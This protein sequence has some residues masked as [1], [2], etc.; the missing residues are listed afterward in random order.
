MK[1]IRQNKKE[2]IQRRT[3]EDLHAANLAK[4]ESLQPST[5]SFP[6]RL[7]SSR[8][9]KPPLQKRHFHVSQFLSLIT[10]FSQL[11]SILFSTSLFLYPP[12][13]FS[14]YGISCLYHN[15]TVVVES[16]RKLL[17]EGTILSTGKKV[18]FCKMTFIKWMWQSNVIYHVKIILLW[19]SIIFRYYDLY[20]VC[21]CPLKLR[22]AAFLLKWRTNI[23]L[24]PN[25]GT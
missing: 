5:S 1:T 17:C 24:L 23:F 15:P 12:P 20:Y 4:H 16:I 13:Y 6:S 9:C 7:T 14:L 21:R 8:G 18:L 2:E 25:A 10:I 11:L 19:C 3:N 22:V